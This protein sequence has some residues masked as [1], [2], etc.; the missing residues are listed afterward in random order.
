[1][2]LVDRVRYRDSDHSYRLAHACRACPDT[3]G[4]EPGARPGTDRK[5]AACKGLGE[6]YTPVPSVTTIL[7]N[8]SKAA[9]VWWSAKEGAQAFLNWFDEHAYHKPLEPWN[10]RHMNIDEGDAAHLYELI[11]TAHNERKTKAADKGSEVHAAIDAWKQDVLTAEPPTNPVALASWNAYVD[12]WAGAGFSCLA[13]ERVVVDP[14]GRYAGRLDLLLEESPTHPANLARGVDEE[15]PLYV[16]DIKTS[17]GVYPEHL[18]QNAA[19]AMAIEEELGREVAG[20]KVLWLPEGATQT[21]VVDRDR[22]EWLSDFMVFEALLPLHDHRRNLD[23]MLR[24]VKTTHGPKD[25]TE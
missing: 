12:W 4:R 22:S 25:E 17:G 10:G 7:G 16:A 1:M 14:A 18:Y 5:C 3:P 21:I 11:R 2:Q 9:L 6:T 13:T 20:T 23:R 8:L 15:L 19:Y 24:A